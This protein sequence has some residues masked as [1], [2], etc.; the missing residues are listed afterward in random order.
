MSGPVGAA[1]FPEY[2]K[3]A[4]IALTMVGVSV[5]EE[6]TFSAM[7]L[8]KSLTRN[9]LQENHL[10]CTV[11][12]MTM[13]GLFPPKTFSFQEAFDHWSEKCRRRKLLA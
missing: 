3:L 6:M 11:R 8:I 4:K 12:A 5:E 1:S 7:N 10:N 13:R 9:R 2:I